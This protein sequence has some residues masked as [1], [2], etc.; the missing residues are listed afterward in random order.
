LRNNNFIHYDDGFDGIFQVTM[1]TNCLNIITL[2]LW[3]KEK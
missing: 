2:K 3:N 1:S